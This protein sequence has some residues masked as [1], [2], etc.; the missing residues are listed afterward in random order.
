MLV[1]FFFPRA[2]THTHTHTHTHT[3][4]LSISPIHIRVACGFL[5]GILLG[6]LTIFVGCALGAAASYFV[7]QR[8]MRQWI[9]RKVRNSRKLSAVMVAAK[10][11]GFKISI[12]LRF[13]PIPVGIQT[14]LLAISNIR[15]PV[16][17]LGSLLGMLPEQLL[18]AYW[19]DAA[20]DL[21][22][23][24]SGEADMSPA[25]IAFMVVGVVVAIFLTVFLVW[26]GRR[27]IRK[28]MR[29]DAEARAALELQDLTSGVPRAQA[30]NVAALDQR[31]SGANCGGKGGGHAGASLI[32]DDLQLRVDTGEEECEVGSDGEPEEDVRDRE[33]EIGK[34][35][36]RRLQQQQPPDLAEELGGVYRAYTPP[37]AEEMQPTQS[38]VASMDE[39]EEESDLEHIA[40]VQRLSTSPAALAEQQQRAGLVGE[41]RR[42]TTSSGRKK[43]A[44]L[45]GT[46]KHTLRK[47]TSSGSGADRVHRSQY[48]QVS[49]TEL[50]D[51]TRTGALLSPVVS[52]PVPTSS[53][54]EHASAH[55]STLVATDL[56]SG[57]LNA[58]SL[59]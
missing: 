30:V 36:R 21:A 51:D 56:R 47:P 41:A 54:E 55:R 6:A 16:F 3:I 45:V 4:Y 29:E 8:F 37:P 18:F 1:V 38:G 10:K 22:Q 25:K 2:Y 7:C 15:F 53:A 49:N 42:P 11:N 46:L 57:L 26:L 48:Q 5:Y 34:T 19:G 32:E 39:L 28:A 59:L 14:G 40:S 9:E 50:A 43:V 33:R 24:A 35:R 23:I 27:A 20:K 58:D 12:L 31:G 52:V 44:A 17:M 13:I